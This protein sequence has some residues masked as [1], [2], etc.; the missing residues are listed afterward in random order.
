MD[1]N[2]ITALIGSRVPPVTASPEAGDWR[3]SPFPARYETADL[4][5]FAGAARGFNV[6]LVSLEST[7]AQYLALYEAPN[8]GQL[9]AMPNL[10]ALARHSVVF[11]N[12]YA[13]YPES[14]KGLFSVLC[15]TFPAFDSRPEA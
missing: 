14:I 5:R 1:R 12:A 4:S 7:A 6:V 2:A 9:D 11:E 10:S 15:S 13:V 8:S 3:R